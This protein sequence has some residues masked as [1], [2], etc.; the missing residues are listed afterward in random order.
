MATPA[1]PLKPEKRRRQDR[2]FRI[3]F[4]PTG[5]LS[6]AAPIAPVVADAPPRRKVSRI[7]GFASPATTLVDD[8]CSKLVE[9]L[10]LLTLCPVR[11]LA[12]DQEIIALGPRRFEGTSGVAC[13]GGGAC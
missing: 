13:G 9:V 11:Q 12:D 6:R 7:L 8:L 5:T 4:R 2:E 1:G 10:L 3:M